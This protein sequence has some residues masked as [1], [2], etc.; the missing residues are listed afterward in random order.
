MI[1]SS[2]SGV[3]IGKKSVEFEWNVKRPTMQ[4]NKLLDALAVR[5]PGE[6]EYLQAVREVLLSVEEV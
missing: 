2:L 4:V 6:D 1:K 3:R 5:H